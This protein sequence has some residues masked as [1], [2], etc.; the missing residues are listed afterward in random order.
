VKGETRK[1]IVVMRHTAWRLRQFPNITKRKFLSKGWLMTSK[2]RT[3]SK[4]AFVDW[5]CSPGGGKS[6]PFGV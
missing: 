1:N 6:G 5:Q 3:F 2:A 4:Q